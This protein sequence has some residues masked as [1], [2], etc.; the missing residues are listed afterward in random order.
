VESKAFSLFQISLENFFKA[1][2]YLGFHLHLQPSEID[3]LDFY[4]YQYYV[5]NLTEHL[6]KQNKEEQEQNEQMQEQYSTQTP[7]VPK[8]SDYGMKMPKMSGMKMPKF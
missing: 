8:M 1:K 7:K 6:K 5:Q 2:F 4:E 3:A